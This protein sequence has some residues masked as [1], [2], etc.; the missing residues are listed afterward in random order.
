MLAA[1][2]SMLPL[3]SSFSTDRQVAAVIESVSGELARHGIQSRVVSGNGDDAPGALLIVTGGTEHLALSAV[4]RFGM[5]G[6]LLAHP[7]RNSL[8]AA[9]ETLSRLRQLGLP[10]RVFL[11]NGRGAPDA[12]LGRLDGHA[13]VFRQL[14]GARLGRIGAP[15][16]WLVGSMPTPASVSA[17]WGPD[18][19]DV[20]MAEVVEAMAAVE[21]SEAV[22]MASDVIAQATGMV[23]AVRA[24]VETAA[25]VALALRQVVA[26]HRLDACTV[27]C[28]DL[29]IEHRTTGCLGLSWLLDRGVVAGCEGDVPATL[30]MMWAQAATGEPAFMANPQ[31]LDVPTRGVWLAHCTVAR[32]LASS[33]A[34]RSHFESSLGVGIQGCLEPGPVTVARIGGADLRRVYAED[35][36]LVANENVAERCRTQVRVALD[37]GVERLLEDPPGNHLVLMR[38]HHAARFREYRELF[39]ARA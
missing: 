32:G 4:E 19:V 3:A 10:G 38:G 17:V 28:F 37:G 36:Q 2:L 21:A 33:Y 13:A 5:P 20:P 31:D 24:D 34:L 1:M 16:D 29:V 39:V 9:L 22:A 12:V 25:T 15:S 30:T 23:E 11:L 7:E 6:F 18:V 35:G 26:R 27:R 8:P 14:R